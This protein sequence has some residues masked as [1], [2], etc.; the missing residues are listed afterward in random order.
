[1]INYIYVVK[2]ISK[3]KAF[4]DTYAY[5]KEQSKFDSTKSL[6]MALLKNKL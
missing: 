3:Y 1:M 4:I 2:Y 5:S 6:V